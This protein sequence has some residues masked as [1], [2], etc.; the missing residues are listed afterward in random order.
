MITTEEKQEFG[1]IVSDPICYH[2]SEFCDT[3]H[4]EFDN[5]DFCCQGC[6]MVYEILNENNL[7]KY[8][9]IDEQAG[10]S[11]RGKTQER[12]AYLDDP[13]VQEKLIEFTDGKNTRVHFHLPQIHCSSCIWLLE[14]LYRLNP[15]ITQSRVDF[16]R[17]EIFLQYDNSQTNLRKI[18]ELLSSIGYAPAINLSNL[19]ANEKQLVEKSYYYKLGT[20]GFAFGNIML[21]SFPEYLGLD[22]VLEGEFFKLFG[23]M[24]ILLSIPVVFYSGYDYLLSAWTG[25]QQKKLTIDVPIA[26]GVLTLFLRSV[27]EILTHSGAGYLDSLA[28]LVFFLLIGKWFQQRTY[29]TISFD[30]DYKSYFPIAAWK[31]SE[32]GQPESIT[33][34]KLVPGDHIIVFNQE[35]IPADGVLITEDARIDYSFVTGEEH[36]VKVISG[37]KVFAGGRQTDGQIEVA[38]TKKVSQSYLTQLWNEDAFTKDSPTEASALADRVGKYFTAVILI[39]AFFTLAYWIPR[40]L[41]IAFNAFTAVLIIACPCA[42]ALS[43]PFTFGNM[44]RILGKNQFYLKNT[45]VIETLRTINTVV[46]DKTGTLTSQEEKNVQY[47]GNSLTDKQLV[48]LYQLAR[49]TNHPLS[50]QISV[51]VRSRISPD[52][53]LPKIGDFE[54]QVGKGVSGNINGQKWLLGSAVFTGVDSTSQG[55]SVYFKIDDTVI[56]GFR[57]KQRYRK[58][59]AEVLSY[60]RQI[61]HTYLLSGD[62]NKEKNNLLPYFEE[63]KNLR[64][65]QSPQDKLHFI[66]ELRKAGNYVLTFGDG[67]NDAGALKQSHTGVVITENTNNFTPACDGILHA[68]QFDKLPSLISFA[69]KG[70]YLVYLAYALA[71]IYNIIGLSFAVQGILS[72][73]IAAIL[74]PASSITIV[75]FGVGSSSLLAH[76][77]KL[78]GT[79]KQQTVRGQS[80]GRKTK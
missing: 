60:F 63:E 1:T 27:F 30:R 70:V 61:G 16:L 54:E 31:K 39:I 6:K 48:G 57:F 36:P 72:P 49:Q 73:V 55:L 51:Y 10:L 45:R 69:R 2:C 8:Y 79:K 53:P 52:L 24:N 75:L 56:G 25:L 5:K 18:V 47:V 11:L 68:D 80:G 19:D 23:Y 17:K 12:Y 76:R 21:F 26:L 13:S 35:L 33:L 29:H 64:F 71:F 65:R 66:E 43:I 7:C 9:E 62:N 44:L 4:I 58:G 3:Q 14:Q 74:M 34:D 41:R 28:G 40:D 67:L 78:S 32:S 15:G 37:E 20:A 77:M 50:R 42:V 59:L 22:K 38:L 46:F